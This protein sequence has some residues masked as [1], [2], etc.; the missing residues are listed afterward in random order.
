M[1]K[2]CRERELLLGNW[3]KAGMVEGKGAID[4]RSSWRGEETPDHPGLFAS[5]VSLPDL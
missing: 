3:T 4:T 5:P 2:P 1:W